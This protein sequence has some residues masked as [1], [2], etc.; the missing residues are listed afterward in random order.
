M[1]AV[2]FLLKHGADPNMDHCK[3]YPVEAVFYAGDT[4]G[5]FHRFGKKQ[6]QNLRNIAQLLMAM[7]MFNNQ[8][9]NRSMNWVLRKLPLALQYP[10][11]SEAK[12][13]PTLLTL[14]AEVVLA[15]FD[16]IDVSEHH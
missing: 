7:T 13:V 4:W 15:N 3:T 16:D 2:C 10:E 8:Q 6:Q 11:I 14:A 12:R 5:L 1:P 9:A